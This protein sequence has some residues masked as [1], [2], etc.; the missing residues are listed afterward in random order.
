M[1]LCNAIVGMIRVAHAS[2][3][4]TW[5]VKAPRIAKVLDPKRSL[6]VLN[7]LFSFQREGGNGGTGWSSLSWLL[8]NCFLFVPP[9]RPTAWRPQ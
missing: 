8:R 7:I 9:G 3:E 5:I 6:Y 1:D 4:L 2:M